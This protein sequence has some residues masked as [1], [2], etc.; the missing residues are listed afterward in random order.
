[1]R[2]VGLYAIMTAPRAGHRAFAEACVECDVRILQLR[3]KDLPDH[4]L[5]AIA[6]EIRSITRDTETMFVINDRPDIATLC[7]A[8]GLHLG[9]S[10]MD[11]DDARKLFG[12]IIGLST[13]SI[14][15]AEEALKRN[16]D[17]IGFGPVFPTPTK[18]IPDPAV[19]TDNLRKAMLLASVPVIA[20]GGIFPEN[21]PEVLGAG[22][23]N[24]AVVRHLMEVDDPR[25]RIRQLQDMIA[26][27]KKR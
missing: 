17:Y 6:R 15:Q 3:E 12:G 2:D 16:P 23:H 1:M 19:G 18:A 24:I 5:I 22:A 14:S 13:H 4:E 10:D 21:L 11:I 8:D 25:D 9:Q 27:Q 7:N 20:I 26:N